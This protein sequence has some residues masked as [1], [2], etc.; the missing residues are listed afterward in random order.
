MQGHAFYPWF[1]GIPHTA[2]QLAPCATTASLSSRAREPQPLRAA[3]PRACAPQSGKPPPCLRLQGPQLESSPRWCTGRKAHTAVT[4]S[5][6][7]NKPGSFFKKHGNTPD[8]EI[9]TRSVC[10][11]TFLPTPFH[12]RPQKSFHHSL[13]SSL[14]YSYSYRA[15]YIHNF[16]HYLH[17]PELLEN[18]FQWSEQQLGERIHSVKRCC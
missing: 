5:T 11:G 6:A 10:P 12:R 18:N 3:R 16:M 4:V 9:Q 17:I 7:R 13:R 8:E 14:N 1:W 2:E 15:F